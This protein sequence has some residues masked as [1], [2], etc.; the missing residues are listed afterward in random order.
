[1]NRAERDRA[2]DWLPEENHRMNFS[3]NDIFNSDEISAITNK[4]VIGAVHE[5]QYLRGSGIDGIDISGTNGV[6][7][8]PKKHK[9]GLSATRQSSL[10][11][12]ASNH[13]GLASKGATVSRTGEQISAEVWNKWKNTDG[14]RKGEEMRKQNDQKRRIS[15]IPQA[16]WEVSYNLIKLTVSVLSQLTGNC[17]P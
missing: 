12:V 15:S 5:S 2:S 9:H 16:R 6:G 8:R 4:H 14:K 13:K 1:M 17:V 10:N 3:G 7:G 11:S